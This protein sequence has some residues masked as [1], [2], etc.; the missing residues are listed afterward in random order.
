[1]QER[2]ILIIFLWIELLLFI[3][4]CPLRKDWTKKAVKYYA[5][6]LV[7]FSILSSD[8]PLDFHE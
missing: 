4:L 7:I 5:Q 6:V 3:K 1:M 2:Y 8:T